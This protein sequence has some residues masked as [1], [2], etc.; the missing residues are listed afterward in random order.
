MAQSVDVVRVFTDAAG[1]HGNEL[2]IVR[3]TSATQ[4]REHDIAAALGFSETV[5]VDRAAGAEAAIRIFTPEDQLRFAGHPTVGTA[6]WSARAGRP[7]EVLEVPAGRLP[8]TTDG[9]LTWITTRPEWS[10]PFEIREVADPAALA[11]IDPASVATP[12]WALY[13]YAWTDR[14]AGALRARMFAPATGIVEDEATGSAASRLTG[15]LRRDLDV[16]Q[17]V[18][19]RITTRYDGEHVHLGGR[20]VFDRSI[21]LPR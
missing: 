16:T 5:F 10:P 7:L 19:S 3:S 12:S 2:G 6:W 20:A 11:A 17:G 15:L 9:D 21:P 13:L 18:G 1:R 4:G 14:P 8:V